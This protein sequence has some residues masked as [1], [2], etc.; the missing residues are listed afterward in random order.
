MLKVYDKPHVAELYTDVEINRETECLS[1][2]MDYYKGMDLD[3]LINVMKARGARFTERQVLD[4]ACQI[5]QAMENCHIYGF[6]HQ[7]LK[8][9]K[10]LLPKPWNPVLEPTVPYLSVSGFGFI[11]YTHPKDTV[12]TTP[13][14][15][16][17]YMAPELRGSRVEFSAK[18]DV[19]AFGCVLYRLCTLKQP[20][21]I[22]DIN[23]YPFD[24]PQY[25]F[26]DTYSLISRMVRSDP[27]QR[28]TVAQVR[29]QLYKLIDQLGTPD[30][31]ECR[32]NMKECRKCRQLF[33][34]KAELL[35]HLQ[36][37]EHFEPQ[38][39]SNGSNNAKSYHCRK[40]STAF[41]TNHELQHHIREMKHTAPKQQ[42]SNTSPDSLTPG[43][44][45]T[46]QAAGNA[47]NDRTARTSPTALSQQPKPSHQPQP[48]KK[49]KNTKKKNSVDPAPSAANIPPQFRPASDRQRTPVVMPGFS[50]QAARTPL[51]MPGFSTQAV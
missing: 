46:K 2:F 15:T 49:K 5:A 4:I 35:V 20:D 16:P 40:C 13:R 23:P 33:T 43:D 12:E 41:P 50:T 27:S 44:T 8:P 1:L 10:I 38:R 36:T 18:S 3:R 29:S 32:S 25:F 47:Q 37:M 21:R 6:L 28:P 14:G 39:S 9:T 24:I 30:M 7:D 26:R 45:P 19:Y 11:K 17:G 48:P 42:P 22:D 34:T 31:K 51:M